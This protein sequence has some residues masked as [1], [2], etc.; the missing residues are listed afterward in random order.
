MLVSTLEAICR[1]AICLGIA[2][3]KA[4]FS[5]SFL[6]RFSRYMALARS[7]GGWVPYR[8]SHRLIASLE[9]VREHCPPILLAEV[10][11]LIDEARR[12]VEMA[13]MFRR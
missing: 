6:D 1:E 2:S 4:D 10:Q 11:V 13:R 8:V 5:R 3:S 9:A 7:R 12:G